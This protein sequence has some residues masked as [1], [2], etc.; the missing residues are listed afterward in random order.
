M[1]EFRIIRGGRL[2]D[3]AGRAAPL[4]DILIR[5]GAI[6][7]IG[8][9]GLAAPDDAEVIDAG[10]H[11]LHA[12]L[13]NGHTHGTGAL[14][15]GYRD[16]FNL[17]LL[18]LA[19]PARFANQSLE[20]KYLNT[21]LG[22]VEMA[23]KG[24]TLAFDLTFGLPVASIEELEAMGQAYRDAGI[25]AVMAPML[26]DTTFYRGIP[27]LVESLP[28]DLRALARIDGAPATERVLALMGEALKRWPHDRDHVKLGI[29]PTIPLVCSDELMLGCDRLAREHGTVIQS[30]IGEA[31]MQAVSAI[32]K[33]GKTMLA[34][35]DD[36]GVL[37]PHFSI[38][39]GIWLDDDD[40]RR[41]A[42]KGSSISHNAGSNMRLGSGI[43]D[44]RRMLEF[45]INLAIGTDGAVSSDNQN[46]YEAMRAAGQVAAVR[47][48]DHRRWLTAPEIIDAATR[49][50]AQMAGFDHVGAIAVGKR[51]DIVFLSLDHPNWMPI[52]D[53]STQLVFAEDATAVR[54]VMVDGQFI[55]RDGRHLA[56]DM[57][58][59]ADKAEAARDRML[60]LN[61][62]EIAKVETLE[63]AVTGFCRGLS[64]KPYRV[65]RYAA[66][67][68]GCE[69]AS[70]F[71]A[72]PA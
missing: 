5:D 19:T 18:L 46:M 26:A 48:P 55:V 30:H 50:G 8:A 54:H 52:N 27:G 6:L 32:E 11:L 68:C 67:P 3:A 40:L 34:R 71:A 21:Y 7:E 53:P 39:H 13:V 28:D 31:K 65:E 51:A 49:G 17:E 58:S 47:Q 14:T 66:F 1:S 36:L 12:G 60:E 44:A 62:A 69:E 41:V 23:M 35:V 56:S 72:T 57:A 15:R 59:L 42:E 43:A 25:R 2:L 9:P 64:M 37:G 63:D 38:A 20:M 29:A 16:R 33:Y 22:A 61:A 10:R 70:G 24:C 45:G 4:R